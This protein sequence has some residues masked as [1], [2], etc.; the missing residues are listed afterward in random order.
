MFAYITASPFVYIEHFGVRPS[1]YGYLFGLNILG[2]LATTLLNARLVRRYRVETVLVLEALAAA[3]AGAALAY[4][5]VAGVGGLGAIV[6]LLL[7][8][9][10]VTGPIGA[11]CIGLL[12][13]LHRADAGTASAAFG[14]SQFGLGAVA[15]ACVG[16]IEGP[17]GLGLM[18]GACGSVCLLSIAV[19]CVRWHRRD[20]VISSRCSERIGSS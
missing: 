2:I 9:V 14:T 8:Y 1:H 5:T 18:V 13:G 15:S 6:A 17:Q 4:V 16:F 3:F 10:G 7:V 20:A 19:A 11:N 12:L